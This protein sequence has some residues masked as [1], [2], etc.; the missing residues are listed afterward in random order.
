MGESGA[1]TRQIELSNRQVMLSAR[2]DCC[3]LAEMGR[4]IRL[5][6]LRDL[7]Q[8]YISLLR[9]KTG[10]LRQSQGEF[11]LRG[12]L[13]AV[14]PVRGP[15]VCLND[16]NS[17]FRALVTSTDTHLSLSWTPVDGKTYDIVCS[18]DL[19]ADTSWTDYLTDVPYTVGVDVLVLIPIGSE[20][21]RFYRVSV[22]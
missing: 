6:T 1:A 15:V 17:T 13:D 4:D 8:R 20:R 3:F 10:L 21:R 19:G 11:W 5:P 9:H 16:A 2:M 22:K 7:S 14:N 12:W 18:S